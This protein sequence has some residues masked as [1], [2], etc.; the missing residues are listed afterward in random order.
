MELRLMTLP[1]RLNGFS[2]KENSKEF[3][4]RPTSLGNWVPAS[5]Q[6]DGGALHLNQ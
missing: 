5:W 4:I 6:I 1:V 3:A 2:N